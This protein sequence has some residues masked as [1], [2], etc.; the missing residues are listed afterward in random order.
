M[1]TISGQVEPRHQNLANEADCSQTRPELR[2]GFVR[3]I[4]KDYYYIDFHATIDAIKYRVFSLT[5]EVK[6]LYR[7]SEEKKDYFCP[8]CKSK[9]TQ[10]EVLDK[11]GP[12]GFECHRCGGL[13]EREE[14]NAGDATGHEKQRRLMTQLEKVLSMLQQVDSEDI[15]NNDFET[16]IALSVPVPRE[17]GTGPPRTTVADG[18]GGRP[19]AVK[20][21]A[22]TAAAPLDVSVTASAAIQ[23]TEAQQKADLAAQNVLPAWHT[24]STV[25][26][27]N[28]TGGQ[29]SPTEAGL[30]GHHDLS[31]KDEEE[32]KSTGANVLNDE[33]TAYYAQ[34]AQEKEK[35]AREDREADESSGGEENGDGED[36]DDFEDVGLN[37]ASNVDT[38][39]SSFA[40]GESKTKVDS[41]SGSSGAVTG[42]STPAAAITIDGDSVRASKKVKFEEHE[43]DSNKV[44]KDSDEDDE[45]EFE[46]V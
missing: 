4:N 2:E 39:S 44:G 43:T 24:H 46:D 28:F 8:Q 13:L 23:A 35:E 32:G 22:Q 27:E 31:A 38:P 17:Q 26:G 10:L 15:P 18:A 7:P 21:M 30:N 40:A 36:D 33:L 34:M 25:T 12:M 41:E 20:G 14:P 45:I 29:Q 11:V 16:A 37:T 1:L 19:T 3:P 42:N 6:R 9:W 5:E